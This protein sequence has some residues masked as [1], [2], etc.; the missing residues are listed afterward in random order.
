[1]YSHFAGST[2]AAAL[3]V[4]VAM[5]SDKGLEEKKTN[6][7]KQGEFTCAGAAAAV[8]RMPVVCLQAVI[9]VSTHVAFKG[10]DDLSLYAK[11]ELGYDEVSAAYTS[12]VSMW[13]N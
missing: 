8:L 3:L 9:I 10:L 5:S 2:F 12:T 7:Q 4:W 13:V 11:E 1:M 6:Q